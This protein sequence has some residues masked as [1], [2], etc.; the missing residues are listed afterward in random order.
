M[1]TVRCIVSKLL[2]DQDQAGRGSSLARIYDNLGFEKRAI[3]E[4]AKSLSFDP[5]NHSAHRFLS[6]TYANIQR[7]EVARVSELLQAQLLQP[8]N[9]NPVQ[10]QLAVADLNV[11]TN[12][13]PTAVGFNEFTPLME[14]NKPQL[15]ASLMGG[16]HDTISNETVLSAVYDRV[17]ASL[18]Q[19]HF[20]SD[21]F[22]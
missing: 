19:Y 17:S 11:I 1:I 7:H 5:A 22:S 4:T 16:S 14:R 18:G 21:G 9:V 12:T 8:I 13:G 2:L 15:V 6:D 3:M 20:Q 10:P